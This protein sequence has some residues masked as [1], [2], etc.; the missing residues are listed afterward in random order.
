MNYF[1]ESE[2]KNKA[3]AEKNALN[4]LGL[5]ADD[6]VFKT[7]GNTGKGFLGMVSRKPSV[8]RVQAKSKISAETYVRGVLLTILQK[9]GIDSVIHSIGEK[10]GNIYVEMESADSRILIGKQGRTLDALQFIVNLLIEQKDRDGR[11][12]MLDVANYRD[13][14]QKRLSRL[15]KMVADK[16]IKTRQPI[17]LDYMN[18][19]ERRI[20]HLALEQDEKVYTKSD[21]NGIY[22]RVKI[23]PYGAD[24]DQY[25]KD[26]PAY[27]DEY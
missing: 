16:V 5:E 7:G 2:G 25:E 9:M 15:A 17:S 21:G 10:D 20:V 12:V 1:Y 24:M 6:V 26:E 18:P 19:Y 13:K 11:R 8:V 27:G 3:E 4:V 22:K 14:R 23:I